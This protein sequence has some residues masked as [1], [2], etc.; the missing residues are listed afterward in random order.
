MSCLIVPCLSFYNPTIINSIGCNN[1][2]MQIIL[3]NNFTKHLTQPPLLSRKSFYPSNSPEVLLRLS[4][5]YAQRKTLKPYNEKQSRN[6]SKPAPNWK[7]NQINVTKNRIHTGSIIKIFFLFSHHIY[8]TFLNK[9]KLSF[10]PEKKYRTSIFQQNYCWQTF[11][12]SINL[13]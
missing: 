10:F 8:F 2:L 1:I 13:F 4:K 5:K 6:K 12:S 9:E 11:T 3:R 7:K